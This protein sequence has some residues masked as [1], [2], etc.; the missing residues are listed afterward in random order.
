MP[1]RFQRDMPAK[2]VYQGQVVVIVDANCYSAAE[3]F[4]A[5]MQDHGL[6]RIVGTDTQTGGGGGVVWSDDRIAKECRDPE[7]RKRLAPL[8]GGASFEVAVLRTTRTGEHAGVP[9]EDMG[10]V[11][12]EDDV[13]PLTRDD[14]LHGNKDLRSAAIEVLASS[15]RATVRATFAGGAFTITTRGVDRV[16]AWVHGV[17]VKT[18]PVCGDQDERSVQLPGVARPPSGDVVFN[19]LLRNTIVTSFV[20]RRTIPPP[21]RPQ[22]QPPAQQAPTQAQ[23]QAP[24]QPQPKDR[25]VV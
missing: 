19:G 1:S 16:D 18:V 3:M 11:V 17:P 20:W 15:P 8:P 6:A 25:E 9:V 10:V 14:V 24:A 23:P 7:M 21:A 12:P 2:Q 5:G 13:H 22:P 4:V